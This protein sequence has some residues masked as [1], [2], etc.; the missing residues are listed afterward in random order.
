MTLLDPSLLRIGLALAALVLVGLWSHGRRRRRLGEFLGGRRATARLSRSDLSRRGV[1]RALLL[2]VA[3]LALATAAAEPRWLEAPEP[4]APVSDVVL[5]IDVSASMQARDED[6]NR[7]GQA[8][9]V[10]NRMLDALDGQ[11]VGLLIFAGKTYPLAPP[12]LDHDAL[13]FLLRGITP[14]IATAYDPGTLLSVAISDAVTLLGP[15]GD[16]ASVQPASAASTAGERLVVLIGDGDTGEPD[17]PVGS[18]VRAARDGGVMIHT[19][20]V[21]TERGAGMSLTAGAYQEGGPVLDAAGAPGRSRL[22][23]ALLRQVASAGGGRYVRADSP[24]D[25]AALES[26]LRALSALPTP[27][28][29]SDVPPWT[30][31]DVPLLLGALALAL[32]TIES[33]FGVSLP[34]LVARRPH[35]REAT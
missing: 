32:V 8:V 29:T 22:R 25:L 4:V 14:T 2:G 31:Y 15:A 16:S 6:P 21:G 33:L 28:P 19:V 26:D 7:L 24:D 3:G 23:E 9:E 34:R 27:D 12:T 20:G 35:A 11:E 17:G 30:R 5:A 13:R 10:A 18:A 1:G